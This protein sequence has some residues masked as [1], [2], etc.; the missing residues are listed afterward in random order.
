VLREI[1]RSEAGEPQRI[2]IATLLPVST[3]DDLSLLYAYV[4]S[5]E[6]APPALVEQVRQRAAELEAELERQLDAQ[7]ASEPD[8]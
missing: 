6:A 1:A 7:S 4:A 8:G 5:G 2:A 3:P